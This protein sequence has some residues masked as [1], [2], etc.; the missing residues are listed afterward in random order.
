[1]ITLNSG[2]VGGWLQEMKQLTH[3]FMQFASGE[4]TE[5]APGC[6]TEVQLTGGEWVSVNFHP[7]GS[8][9]HALFA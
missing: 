6:Q 1:M 2:C 5:E 3:E 4:T 7:W 8:R 9:G